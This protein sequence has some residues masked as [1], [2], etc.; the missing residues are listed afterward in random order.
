M[1]VLA[2]TGSGDAPVTTGNVDV[3][4]T[5]S[6]GS[7]VDLDEAASTCDD[8]QPDG[9]NLNAS[10]QCIVVFTSPT[11]GLVTGHATASI[12]VS[13]VPFTIETDGSGDNSD[14]AEKTFVDA[15]ITVEA[16]DTN[17]VGDAH[18]FTVTV[19]E[20]AGDGAGFVPPPARLV[21]IT[22]PGGAPGTVNDDDCAT[23]GTDALGQCFVVGQQRRPGR[24]RRPRRLE[25]S[26][27]RPQPRA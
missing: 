10:G 2:D 24:L 25:C 15:Y 12:T 20:N 8:N 23:A 22:F 21:T 1:T 17:E 4:L 26:G 16:D 6:N 11:A 18:T 13:G 19:Y 14:D 27:R 7:T 3:T 5:D 9:D